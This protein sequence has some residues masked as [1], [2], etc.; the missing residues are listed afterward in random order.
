MA[1]EQQ[2]SPHKK[3]RFASQLHAVLGK[4]FTKELDREQKHH[5]VT[6]TD[7]LPSDDYSHIKIYLSILGKWPKKILDAI[8][9]REP[10]IRHCVSTELKFR[11]APH[12]T[13]ILDTTLDTVNAVEKILDSLDS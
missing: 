5:L 13:F 2:S 12:L 1:H 10:Y 3:E 4:I 8:Q 6:I 7:V 9:K 11:R